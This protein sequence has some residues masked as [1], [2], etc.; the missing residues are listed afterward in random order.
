M[1][2]VRRAPRSVLRPIER[3]SSTSM[4]AMPAIRNSLTGRE[5]RSRKA[6]PTKRERVA[7]RPRACEFWRT[8]GHQSINRTINRSINHHLITHIPN[9][10]HASAMQQGRMTVGSAAN[11][12]RLKLPPVHTGI[13]T[14]GDERTA[15]HA[16]PNYLEKPNPFSTNVCIY[17]TLTCARPS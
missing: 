4:P 13:T 7:I 3:G 8:A 2:S 14:T 12:G 9:L 17:P 1:P 16:T 10:S 6:L 15:T 5:E 11:G